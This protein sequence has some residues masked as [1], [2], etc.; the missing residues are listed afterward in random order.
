L[1]YNKNRQ[2]K[3]Q[4]KILVFMALKIW[5]RNNKF[6][7]YLVTIK[8]NNHS[9]RKYRRL[10]QKSQTYGKRPSKRLQHL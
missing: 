3:L 2:Q 9:N 8:I 7:T 1:N 10:Q 5:L 6:A 4:Q